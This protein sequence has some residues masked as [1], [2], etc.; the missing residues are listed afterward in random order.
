ML[1]NVA[2]SLVINLYAGLFHHEW[3]NIAIIMLPST[4]MPVLYPSWHRASSLDLARLRG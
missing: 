2:Q 4:A 3:A 1:S